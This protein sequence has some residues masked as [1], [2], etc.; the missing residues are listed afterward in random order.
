MALAACH[1]P[2]F[3]PI[4][5]RR[6]AFLCRG[7]TKIAP[8]STLVTG[9]ELRTFTENAGKKLF[10]SSATLT[11]TV[12]ASRDSNTELAAPEQQGHSLCFVWTVQ[13]SRVFPW[14]TLACVFCSKCV[15]LASVTARL[16]LRQPFCLLILIPYLGSY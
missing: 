10:S 9:G 13:V 15:L 12:L 3:N 14:V 11:E 5:Q 16:L 4:A 8:P 7:E 6:Q 2:P 1:Y